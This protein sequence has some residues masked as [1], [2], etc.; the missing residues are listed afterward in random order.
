MDNEYELALENTV[1]YLMG[2]I[3]ELHD[4]QSNALKIVF[5]EN[6]KDDELEDFIFLE[7][8]MLQGSR[9]HRTFRELGKNSAPHDVVSVAKI[10][11][12]KATKNNANKKG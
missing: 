1:K 7:F 3:M 12:E 5:K 8:P 10:L 9:N 11:I 2:Y 4:F 6:R